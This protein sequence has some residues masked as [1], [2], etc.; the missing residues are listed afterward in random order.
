MNLA[1][2]KQLMSLSARNTEALGKVFWR[3]ADE[4]SLSSKQIAIILDVTP[5][6]VSNLRRSLKIPQKAEAYT[7]VG[8]LLGIKKCLEIQYPVNPAV[9]SAWL[10]KQRE[11]FQNK[12]AIEFI[13]E[14]VFQT[15]LRLFQ[16]RRLMDLRRVG[17]IPELV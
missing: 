4:Y 5:A 13:T 16:V 14:D 3:L 7:R 12:S 8:Q 1:K 6:Q 11:I 9:K 10:G 2:R 15:G 17:T